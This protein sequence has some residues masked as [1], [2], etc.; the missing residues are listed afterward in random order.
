MSKHLVYVLGKAESDLWHGGH[1]AAMGWI[2]RNATNTVQANG[3]SRFSLFDADE[4][5]LMRIPVDGAA[6]ADASNP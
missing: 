2:L 5:L 3:A 6:W 4:N 1:K